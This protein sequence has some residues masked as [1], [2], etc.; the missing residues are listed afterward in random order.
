MLGGMTLPTTRE[1]ELREKQIRAATTRRL[2]DQ[3]INHMLREKEKFMQNPRLL[4]FICIVE[5]EVLCKSQVLVQVKIGLELA[6]TILG[7]TNHKP[8]NQQLN[9]LSDISIL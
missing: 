5:P 9:L 7:A 2:G 4:S 8:I 3:E 6:G 1:V